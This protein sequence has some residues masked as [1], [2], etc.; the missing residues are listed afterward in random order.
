[1][2]FTLCIRRRGRR[3][4]LLCSGVSRGLEAR[5][6]SFLGPHARSRQVSAAPAMPSHFWENVFEDHAL[7]QQAAFPRARSQWRRDLSLCLLRLHSGPA[8]RPLGTMGRV[9]SNSEGRGCVGA[10]PLRS[11]AHPQGPSQRSE[12]TRAASLG[13]GAPA[14]VSPQQ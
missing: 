6:G 4:W 8:S 14:C 10:R 5:G 13:R 3:R 7:P 1:M 2:S 9:S 11:L 12:D